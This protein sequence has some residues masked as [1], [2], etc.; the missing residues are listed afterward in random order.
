VRQQAPKFSLP[1][2]LLVMKSKEGAFAVRD[3]RVLVVDMMVLVAEKM[4]SVGRWEM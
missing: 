1:L 2:P 4:V 3:M